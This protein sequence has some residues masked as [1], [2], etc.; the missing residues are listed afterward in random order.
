MADNLQEL[1]N[2]IHEFTD[3]TGV[4]VGKL[5]HP[6]VVA[7]DSDNDKAH[8]LRNEAKVIKYIHAAPHDHSYIVNKVLLPS[9]GVTHDV[10]NAA[11]AAPATPTEPTEGEEDTPRPVKNEGAPS[12]VELLKLKHH[13]YVPEVVREPRMHF[14]RVP[15]L[16]SFMAIP[17]EYKSCLFQKSLD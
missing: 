11:E 14:Y 3:A 7:K 2:F 9:Q 1:A 15:R 17:L 5:E 10:F 8:V 16:G 4:Y 12:G 13:V 6:R